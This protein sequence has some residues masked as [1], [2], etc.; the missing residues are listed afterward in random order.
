MASSKGLSPLA[1]VFVMQHA[2]LRFLFVTVA[3]SLLSACGDDDS[4]EQRVRELIAQVEAAAEARDTSEVTQ[5]L[6]PAYRDAHGNSIDDVK[7]LL[8][9]YF[10]AN[11]SISL[12]T[13]VEELTFPN[14]GEARATVLVGMVSREADAA[15][16]WELAADLNEFEIALAEEDGEWRVTW[17]RWRR[18]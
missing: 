10:I 16:A 13:R 2:R 15:N 3:L 8:R 1:Q 7:R 9:G 5:W 11:Q 6:S 18:N 12:L 14:P 4:P 17:A